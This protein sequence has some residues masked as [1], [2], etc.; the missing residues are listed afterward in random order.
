MKKAL[1]SHRL[2][3]LMFLPLIFTLNY[4][5]VREIRTFQT[6]LDINFSNFESFLRFLC[7]Y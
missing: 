3:F 2:L 6:R 7:V 1:S 4:D 5:M